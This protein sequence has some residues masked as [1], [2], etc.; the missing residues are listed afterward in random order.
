MANNFWFGLSQTDI[1]RL[2]SLRKKTVP[3]L[4]EKL[5]RIKKQK[6]VAFS[7][8]TLQRRSGNI[9]DSK[10]TD[11]KITSLTNSEFQIEKAIKLKQLR[12]H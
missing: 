10:I 7:Q 1:N 4:K 6:E 5:K 11:R 9:Q 2:E 3:I 12:T 8:S